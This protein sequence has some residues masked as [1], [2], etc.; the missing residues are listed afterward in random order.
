MECKINSV[1]NPKYW[2]CSW[3]LTTP[4]IQLGTNCEATAIMFCAL[5]L[6]VY[7]ITRHIVSNDPRVED[8]LNKGLNSK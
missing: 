1:R 4:S 8:F 3:S 7:D 6:C 5:G 2:I